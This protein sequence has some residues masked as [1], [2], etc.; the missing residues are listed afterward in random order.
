MVVMVT[1]MLLH[2]VLVV[3]ATVGAIAASVRVSVRDVALTSSLAGAL[4][5]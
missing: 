5:N 4:E 1:L 3:D 2:Y